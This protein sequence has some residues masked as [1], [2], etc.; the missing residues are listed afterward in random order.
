MSFGRGEVLTLIGVLAFTLQIVH[1]GRSAET[2][3]APRLTMGSFAIAACAGWAAAAVLSPGSIGAA[4]SGLAVSPRFWTYF[5]ITLFGATIGAMLL[6]NTFQRFVRPSEAAIVYTTE[7]LFATAFGILF[8][9]RGEVPNAWGMAG[10]A[11]TIA[12]NLLV[13]LKPKRIAR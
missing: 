8:I 11:L 12:A 5:A 9:G 6:M 7:P 1:T 3:G 10:A 2:L 13:A 4:I